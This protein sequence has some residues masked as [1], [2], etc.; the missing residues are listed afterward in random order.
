MDPETTLPVTR[1]RSLVLNHD[2]SLLN[3]NVDRRGQDKGGD[4]VSVALSTGWVEY[5]TSE[6]SSLTSMYV[7]E[8]PLNVTLRSR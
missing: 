5:N 7:T 3:P 6:G 1:L 2:R 8:N 4:H